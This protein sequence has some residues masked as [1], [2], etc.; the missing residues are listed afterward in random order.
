[1]LVNCVVLAEQILTQVKQ[2]I[3]FL[4]KRPPVLNVLLIGNKDDSVIYVKKKIKTARRVGTHTHLCSFVTYWPTIGIKINLEQLPSY[5]KQQYVEN[6]IDNWNRDTE[7]DGI[8]VQL[9]MVADID[10]QAIVSRI[11]LQKDVDGLNPLNL[12]RYSL[13]NTTVR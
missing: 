13:F 8:M 3:E 7:V 2:D 5:I 4:V 6:L 10:E 9:P 11:S 12:A 1:M